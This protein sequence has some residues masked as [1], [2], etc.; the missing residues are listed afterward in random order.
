MSQQPIDLLG[1]KSVYCINEGQM[2]DARRLV[3]QDPVASAR[4]Q[5]EIERLESSLK[6][7][8]RAALAFLMIE[9]LLQ[10]SN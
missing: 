4:I 3:E 2:R 7:N 9:R 10:D 6:R 8:E 5:T 1:G